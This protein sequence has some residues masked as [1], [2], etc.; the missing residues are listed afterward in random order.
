MNVKTEKGKSEELRDKSSVLH[1]LNLF[2]G[3]IDNENRVNR[4]FIVSLNGLI[5]SAML[6]DDFQIINRFRTV[7]SR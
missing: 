4:R 5:L 3:A 1:D 2:P 7:S 6:R